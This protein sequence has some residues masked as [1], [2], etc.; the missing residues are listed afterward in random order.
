LPVY[1]KKVSTKDPR[2]HNRAIGITAVSQ[3]PIGRDLTTDVIPVDDDVVLCNSC[4]ANVNNPDRDCWG[5]LIY[6]D[7]RDVKADRPY[8]FY[9]DGCVQHSFP[10]AIDVTNGIPGRIGV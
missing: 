3:T 4:N 2:F 8:D 7:K 10:K 5:W 1:K 6:F 9:C